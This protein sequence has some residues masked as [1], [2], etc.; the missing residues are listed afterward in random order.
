MAK[1][2]DPRALLWALLGAWIGI[3]LLYSSRW[4]P[5]NPVFVQD[6]APAPQGRP[7]LANLL[8]QLPRPGGA[9]PRVWFAPYTTFPEPGYIESVFRR[10]VYDTF[11][12]FPSNGLSANYGASKLS[13]AD[14]LFSLA[15]AHGLAAELRLARRLGYGFFALDL[16]AVTHAEAAQALCQRSPGCRIT[17]DAYALWPLTQPAAI[18]ALAQGL[19]PLSRRLPL[20]PQR[21]AGP[22]WGPLVFSPFQWGPAQL[23]DGNLTL[24]AQPGVSWQVYRYPLDRYS[25]SIQV[26]LQLAPDAVQ[27]VLAADVSRLQLCIRANQN[28]PCHSLRLDANRRRGAIGTLLPAGQLSRLELVDIERLN[29]DTAPFAMEVRAPKTTQALSAKSE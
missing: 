15:S 2:A 20:M 7:T 18:A 11:L 1:A 6:A 19:H 16:G 24:Q 29:A 27:L 12:A 17:S 21:S 10:G 28:E 5:P 9:Q 13:A 14:T 23:R 4:W 22:S 3:E 8:Q 25:R 26:W